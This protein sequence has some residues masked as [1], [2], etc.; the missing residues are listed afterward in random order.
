VPETVLDQE[1]LDGV[2]IYTDEDLECLRDAIKS[3]VAECLVR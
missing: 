2:L 1:I 3:Y